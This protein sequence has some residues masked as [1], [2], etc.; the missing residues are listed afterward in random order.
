YRKLCATAKPA[1]CAA[2]VKAD[3][4]GLG[5]APVVRSLARAGCRSFFVATVA[6]GCE[7]RALAPNAVIYVLGGATPDDVAALVAAGLVPVLNSR[8][9]IECWAR[10]GGR[11]PAALHIDTGMSRLGLSARDVEQL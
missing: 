8:A 6:E 9:Q 4:Y 5:V 2:V 1:E 7:V 11:A 3:A 10:A